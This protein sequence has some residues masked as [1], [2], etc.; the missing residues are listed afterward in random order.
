MVIETSTKVP[1]HFVYH[2]LKTF[3]LLSTSSKMIQVSK[4]INTLFKKEGSLGKTPP[5]KIESFLMTLSDLN[6]IVY[7]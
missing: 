4:N 5:T 6:N 3:L 7:R 2:C 1:K